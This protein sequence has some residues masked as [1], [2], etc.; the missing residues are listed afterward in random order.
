[1]EATVQKWGNSLGLRIPKLVATEL[2]IEAG[3]RVG[4]SVEDHRLVISVERRPK[5]SLDTL[6][7]GVKRTNLHEEVE[8]GDPVGNESW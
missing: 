3:T 8:W 5:Y 2:G 6:L 7:A 1:M 4:V